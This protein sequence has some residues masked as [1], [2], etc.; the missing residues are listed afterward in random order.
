MTASDPKPPQLVTPASEAPWWVFQDG[1]CQGPFRKDELARLILAKRVVAQALIWRE[2]WSEWRPVA[3]GLNELAGD[4]GSVRSMEPKVG[5]ERRVGAP[6]I[7]MKGPVHV[8]GLDAS[9]LRAELL[10]ISISGLFLNT[11]RPHL[12][13]G[14]VVQLNVAS[15]DLGLPFD[16]KAE[17]TR[18]N[19]DA[20]FDVGYGFR[21]IEV[22]NQVIVA[23]T[24]LVGYR[25]ISEFGDVAAPVK[26][27]PPIEAAKTPDGNG[28][29]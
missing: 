21:F 27:D 16:A 18:Y 5:G 20:R 12:Q 13:I 24:K 17:V 11:P 8:T 4:V 3:A 23:I 22:D 25:P 14:Q 2:G 10:N 7:P 9:R 19:A 6:R 29:K 26:K 15:P 28:K 1:A